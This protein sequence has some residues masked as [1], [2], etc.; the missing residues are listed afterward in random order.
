ESFLYSRGGD[1]T[2]PW[3]IA[4]MIRE[5]CEE[6]NVIIPYKAH[7]AATLIS[8]GADNIIMAPK[9]ELGP[10]DPTFKKSP[11]EEASVE[12]V[13]SYVEFIKKRAGITDQMALANNI[14]LLTTKIDPLM[15]G[16]IQRTD[17]HIKYVA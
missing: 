9:G 11:T 14:S 12:D 3:R 15:I 10:V 1:T 16:R 17:N 8:L 4:S 7:S 13:K 5:F 2:V 6:F